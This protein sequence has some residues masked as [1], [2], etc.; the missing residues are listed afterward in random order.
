[1]VPMVS[2]I[3]DSV[4]EQPAFSDQAAP[5]PLSAISCQQECSDFRFLGPWFTDG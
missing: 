2:Q 1:M 4:Q 3:A 5:R